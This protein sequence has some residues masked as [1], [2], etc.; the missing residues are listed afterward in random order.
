MGRT[1][2]PPEGQ[3]VLLGM[4]SCNIRAS[5]S[6]PNPPRK[7][8]RHADGPPCH[9]GNARPMWESRPS[10]LAPGPR[11]EGASLESDPHWAPIP[12]RPSGVGLPPSPPTT[13]CRRPTLTA[14]PRVPQAEA[15]AQTEMRNRG[16]AEVGALPRKRG[17]ALG[18]DG[19]VQAASPRPMLGS[20]RLHRGTRAP[21]DGATTEP[22]GAPSSRGQG[23][24][25][26]GCGGT[27]HPCPRLAPHVGSPAQ[28]AH[29]GAEPWGSH[30][31]HGPGQTPTGAGG[32][33]RANAHLWGA[34]GHR[35]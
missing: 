22:H 17:P 11:K 7:A 18:R 1:R 24:G 23:L 26:P 21:R 25:V 34:A 30:G 35:K 16:R 20:E 3:W 5:P 4:G 19:H 33:G 2:E 8:L 32:P 13:K 29:G 31:A 28:R 9:R 10:G 6:P 14:A 27:C 15:E 12:P